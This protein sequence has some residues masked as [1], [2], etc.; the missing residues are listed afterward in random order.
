MYVQH[1]QSQVVNTAWACL[2]LM[3]ARYP[4]KEAIE[5]GL[6]LIM[7]RQQN[8]GEWYQ[9]DV[10]GVFNNTCMIG[11]PN[12]KLYFTSWALGRYHHVYLP[13]L[14]EMDSS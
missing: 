10:E 3:H 2:A 4:F 9:E 6:K 5:K 13:M 14:K 11:Y 1:E 8:N 12:Y 7:S